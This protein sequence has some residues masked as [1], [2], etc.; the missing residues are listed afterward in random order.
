MLLQV[1]MAPD[2]LTAF[3]LWDAFPDQVDAAQRALNRRCEQA[4]LPKVLGLPGSIRVILY[5]YCSLLLR[6]A[7]GSA[8][9]RLDGALCRLSRLRMGMA[10][11]LKAKHVPRLEFRRDEQSDEVTAVEQIFA[12][13]EQER[14][15]G[16]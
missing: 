16:S 11:L 15:G 13:L 10:K 4:T 14:L 3:V 9:Q 2:N 5:Y 7:M 8:M 6:A 1:R 12:R